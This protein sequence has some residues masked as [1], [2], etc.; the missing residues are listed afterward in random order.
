VDT[1]APAGT[2][3]YNF[4]I[5]SDIAIAASGLSSGAIVEY[6]AD[7]GSSWQQ[8]VLEG[9]GKWHAHNAGVGTG[10][11]LGVQISD[12][13]GNL[14]GAPVYVGDN[15]A[16]IFTG[17]SGAVVLGNGGADTLDSADAGFLRFEGG[18][19]TDTLHITGSGQSLDLAGLAGKLDSVEVIDLGSGINTLMAY[20]PA[21]AGAIAGGMLT[22]EGSSGTVDIGHHNWL[23]DLL[24][25]AGYHVFLL[26]GT[27]LRV[28]DNLSIVGDTILLA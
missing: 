10:G 7:G 28:A 8:A 25:V 20:S 21:N 19:G 13:A 12:V 4:A 18:S 3:D 11:Y 17:S 27:T 26:G 16:G 9:D 23:L 5:D 22:I 14:G 15:Y 6:S 2:L 24:P 1:T